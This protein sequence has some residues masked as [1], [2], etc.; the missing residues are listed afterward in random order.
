MVSRPSGQWL[1]SLSSLP[2]HVT[3]PTTTTTHPS[4]LP[5]PP[6]TYPCTA[7][8][9]AGVPLSGWGLAERVQQR[10][11]Q[12]IWTE[13]PPAC[14]GWPIPPHSAHHTLQMHT[15]TRC[16]LRPP[17]TPRQCGFPKAGQHALAT[18]NTVWPR[19]VV[20]STNDPLN[21]I[22]QSSLTL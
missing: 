15:G 2:P 19:C 10:A 7:R 14:G 12:V 20:L 11:H 13:T 9:E 1:Q 8:A 18:P 5:L 22:K 17:H 16:G 6:G 4:L 21:M 3:F